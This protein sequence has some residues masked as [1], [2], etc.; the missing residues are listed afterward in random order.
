M[1]LDYKPTLNSATGD[2]YEL[3]KDPVTT[4]DEK[5]ALQTEAHDCDE[6]WDALN[7]QIRLRVE[8]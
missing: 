5:L 7:D 2:A 6:R 4:P 8:R 3:I 1:V